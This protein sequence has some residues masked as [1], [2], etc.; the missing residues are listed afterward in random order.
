MSQSLTLTEA[1]DLLENGAWHSVAYVCADRKKKEGGRIIRLAECRMHP[2]STRT[3]TSNEVKTQDKFKRRPHHS[4][5]ATRNLQLRN[6]LVRKFH[7]HLLFS[8][9]NYRV[10]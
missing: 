5:H 10:L 1:L 2:Q 3:D 9:N 8:I 7:I 6:G 4:E